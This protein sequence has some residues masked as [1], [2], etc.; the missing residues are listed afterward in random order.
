M[1]MG[2][3]PTS[4]ADQKSKSSA[5]ER[6]TVGRSHSQG[7]DVSGQPHHTGCALD[8]PRIAFIVHTA[9]VTRHLRRRPRPSASCK[10]VGIFVWHQT[11][12]HRSTSVGSLSS[13]IPMDST[14]KTG[15]EN[16]DKFG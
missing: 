1:Q 16:K 14:S 2:R 10:I 15:V 7:R 6:F 13:Q 4:R 8:T 9:P 3:R 5:H 12:F 11:L